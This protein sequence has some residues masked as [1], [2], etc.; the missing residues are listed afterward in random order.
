MEVVEK[1]DMNRT[2]TESVE[3]VQT[4]LSKNVNN[5]QLDLIFVLASLVNK[6]DTEFSKY[7]ISFKTLAE[8]YNPSNPRTSTTRKYIRESVEDIMNAK[9]SLRNGSKEKYY[10]WVG[11]CEID[12]EKEQITIQ[13]SNEIRK[14]YLLIKERALTYNL[15]NVLAL[16]TTTQKRL[17]IWAYNNKGFK[18][19]VNISIED[20][21]LLFYGD[22][23]I[24]TYQFL[25][26]YIEPAIK[27]I[28]EKTDLTLSY[29]KVRKDETNSRLVTSLK[30][31]IK[32]N[33][34]KKQK[35]E[36][37]PAQQR[38]DRER[39]K[40]LWQICRDLTQ[41]NT[42]LRIDN[43]SLKEKCKSEKKR[44]DEA[45]YALESYHDEKVMNDYEERKWGELDD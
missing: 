11:T 10:H 25:R 28:N 34:Q 9:F 41:E 18:N 16:R 4:V 36:R 23:N 14:F 5:S 1:I 37:T 38:S 30:F 13:L 6:H 20:A 29:E 32:C 33:Y 43:E 15:K 17:Y 22:K 45:E 31:K 35:K 27:H 42:S 19:D 40:Q 44:A 26:K 39:N 21:K 3:L 8:I 12:W 2:I 7:V 24:E